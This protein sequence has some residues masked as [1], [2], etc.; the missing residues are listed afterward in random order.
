MTPRHT[1]PSYHSP[2]R[3]STSRRPRT[4]RRIAGAVLASGLIAGSSWG[5][6]TLG[7]SAGHTGFTFPGAGVSAAQ[8]APKAQS[9]AP[10]NLDRYFGGQLPSFPGNP[11]IEDD[12]SA[13]GAASDNTNGLPAPWTNPN[14]RSTD[15]QLRTALTLTK[16]P[17]VQGNTATFH[18]RITN[19]RTTAITNPTVS[20]AWREAAQIESLR[21]AQLANLG[22][23]PR[24][25]PAVALQG[26]IEPGQSRDITVE[27]LGSDATRGQP[28]NIA[29]GD[30][31]VLNAPGLLQP[32]AHP[33]VF[34]VGGTITGDDTPEGPVGSLAVTRTAVSVASDKKEAPTPVTML[35][36]LA[37]QTA[38]V[39]GTTGDAPTPAPLYLRNENLAKELGTGGRLRGLLDA[40]RDTTSG[41]EGRE[42][43]AATCL[44][45]DPELIDTVERMTHG[46]RVGPKAPEAVQEQRRLRDSWGELLGG[47]EDNSV[48][49]TGVAAAKA[50]LKDLRELV[51]GGCSVALPYAGADIN[52]VA[53]TGNDWLGVQAFGTGA[54]TIK[55][56]L[57][58][59]P[60]QNIVVPSSGYVAPESVPMLAAGVTQGID[61]DS[62]TRFEAVQSGLPVL[63]AAG[64]VTALVADNTVNQTRPARPVE[65]GTGG[66]DGQGSTEAQQVA[67][68]DNSW[69]QRI[70][71]LATQQNSEPSGQQ[72]GLSGQQ[73]GEQGGQQGGLSSQQSGPGAP[74]AS[75]APTASTA[76]AGHQFTTVAFSGNLGTLLRATG[77]TPEVAPYSNPD[78]RYP[79]E[80]D[81]SAARM[82]TALAGLDLEIARQQ[83]V[84]AVPP[85]NWGVTEEEA[86]AVLQNLSGHLANDSAS[87]AP[88]SR[89]AEPRGELKDQDLASGAATVPYGDP[90][91]SSPALNGFVSNIAGQLWDVTLMMRNDPKIALGREV[92]TRPLFDDLV[93]SLSG[94]SMRVKSQWQEQREGRVARAT[95]V[96]D[97][98]DKLQRSVTLVPPGN[99]FTRTSDSS[100]LIVVARNGLPLP[101]RAKL[102]YSTEQSSG[103]AIDVPDAQ[104]IPARGS[105]TMSLTTEMPSDQGAQQMELWLATADG[106]RISTPVRLGVQS[107]PGLHISGLLITGIALA[108]IVVAARLPWVRRT[109]QRSKNRLLDL[110]ERPVNR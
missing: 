12:N 4:A 34:N 60:Q 103:I 65:P 77:A 109:R 80:Q 33:V 48:E 70:T 53:A 87:P 59:V 8:P 39:S 18:L 38:A 36:P 84:L 10:S 83:P 24:Q 97:V 29:Q 2:E 101:V 89:I 100:P 110:P 32:G 108:G 44:A 35:W 78:S 27:V 19:N 16:L 31:V 88:L 57:G 26:S 69:N 82:G 5:W 1:C 49:G 90:G 52:A 11:A 40:Y 71:R 22:E 25:S 61:V 67:N 3:V 106:K 47:D 54:Q 85:A 64:A 46:Y 98:T 68:I 72:G 102:E 9:P 73:S 95:H 17:R 42:L 13:G 50:W 58:V 99:V 63:P 56:V 45:I 30:R 20:F 94:Y 96:A 14:A 51:K 92:F 55:R 105:I 28:S 104:D 41:Q 81:S 7:D 43:R 93:R 91:A 107:A 23:Y 74:A 15:P 76:P 21:I 79:L 37:A 66:P 6:G 62:S 75:T 86:R